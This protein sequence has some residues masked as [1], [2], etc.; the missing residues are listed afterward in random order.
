MHCRVYVG[1][2]FYRGKI[3]RAPRSGVGGGRGGG[4]GF[5]S[6]APSECCMSD[7]RDTNTNTIFHLAVKYTEKRHV[8]R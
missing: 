1:G 4:I 6:V 3:D 7:V 5:H 8:F 2:F